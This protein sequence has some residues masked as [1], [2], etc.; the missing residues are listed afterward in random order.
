MFGLVTFIRN[1]LYDLGFIKSH[2][3]LKH[4][5]CVGN[6]SVGG[7]GKT[8]HVEYLINLLKSEY[9]LA[10][11]SRGYKRKTS[12]YIIA[13][14]KS[15]AEDIGDEPLLYKTKHPD[16]TVCVE[17]NR[18]KG[19]KKLAEHEPS[20]HVIILDDAF[21]HRPIKCG[22]NIVVSEYENLY[23]NDFL[24]P[25]GRLRESKSGM[26]RADIIVISKTPEKT[27][28]VEIRNV[29]K[30]VKPLPHQH[31]FFSYLKYGD[32]Y[33]I[34][35]INETVNTLQDL[36][37]FRLIVF[38]GIANPSPMITYL[39]EYSAGVSHL[40][41]DDHH[42]Y[43]VADIANIQKYYE[44]FE[45]GNKLIVT[46]EKDLMRLKTPEIWAIAERMNI[47]VLPV[48]VTFKDK[49]EE[50]NEIMLK[51][52]RTNRIYQKYT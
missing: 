38:T 3:P 8:P 4:T 14:D 44:S 43:T 13:N 7:S 48:E 33:S 45:G 42:D 1:R 34:S 6:L 28:P 20:P 30:D 36:F 9:T 46:T 26:H 23:Y 5:I 22:L 2:H 17:V 25:V 19:V 39:K 27:T 10:T 51:D 40:P 35:N 21:Q 16:L 49:A 52:V 37:R 18:V 32:L 41:F 50:F 15:T 29:L 31:V 47:F 12:G 11:L 24:M